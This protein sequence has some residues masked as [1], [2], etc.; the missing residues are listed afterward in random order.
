[1]ANGNYM[2]MNVNFTLMLIDYLGVE[3]CHVVA[4]DIKE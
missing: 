3:P 4:E 1:M 2:T